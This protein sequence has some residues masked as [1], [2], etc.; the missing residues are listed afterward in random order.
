MSQTIIQYTFILNVN[1]MYTFLYVC[2]LQDQTHDLHVLW[3]YYTNRAKL[4]HSLYFYI[5]ILYINVYIIIILY[6]HFC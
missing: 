1:L 6:I 5:Y 2:S 3:H 4:E